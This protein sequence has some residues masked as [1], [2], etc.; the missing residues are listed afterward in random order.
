MSNKRNGQEEN[1]INY[2]SPPENN[3]LVDGEGHFIFPG[4]I[5]ENIE[6]DHIRENH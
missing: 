2:L 5:L 6:S 4:P 3:E 1:I